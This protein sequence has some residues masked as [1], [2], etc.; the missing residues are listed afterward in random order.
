MAIYIHALSVLLAL[1][2]IAHIRFTALLPSSIEILGRTQVCI[3]LFLSKHS[4]LKV[5]ILL[6]GYHLSILLAS[7]VV[8]RNTL[9]RV[10]V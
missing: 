5:C 1:M 8:F 6:W 2:R 4:E 7:H 9:L 10:D 3:M